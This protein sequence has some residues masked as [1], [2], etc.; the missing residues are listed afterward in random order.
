MSPTKKKSSFEQLNDVNVQELVES[1]GQFTYLSWSHAATEL[2]KKFPDSTWEVHEYQIDNTNEKITQPYM[3]TDTGYF[4]KVTVTVDGI[5]RTQIHPVL[6]NRNQTIENPNAFQINTSI[7]RCFAKA[8]ALHGLGLYIFAGEDLPESDRP[9]RLTPQQ[10]KLMNNLVKK[11][12]EVSIPLTEV[13]KIKNAIKNDRFNSSN[14]STSV[15]AIEAAIEKHKNLTGQSKEEVK[16]K[17][18]NQP[19]NNTTQKEFENA[20]TSSS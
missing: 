13:V 20:N 2:L 5:S 19:T 10:L 15:K 17:P 18:V 9:E 11:M 3:K 16:A 8:V 7:Q 4:V 6:D 1:K 14:F 12:E